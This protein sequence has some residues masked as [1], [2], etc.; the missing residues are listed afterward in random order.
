[1]PDVSISW[2][3]IPSEIIKRCHHPIITMSS[4]SST[5]D[6]ETVPLDTIRILNVIQTSRESQWDT[7]KQ[8]RMKD[9][10]P[11][12]SKLVVTVRGLQTKCI[13]RKKQLEER[14]NKSTDIINHGL[15]AIKNP[16]NK[17]R[18]G[19]N[20]WFVE[21][22]RSEVI[23]LIDN[24]EAK[25]SNGFKDSRKREF[26]SYDVNNETM[27]E[28]KMALKPYY[29]S[30]KSEM[31]MSTLISCFWS[32]LEALIIIETLS[33]RK[34]PEPEASGPSSGT[35]SAI[36]ASAS[37]SG[38]NND[39]PLTDRILME[40]LDVLVA[41]RVEAALKAALPPKSS[42]SSS[43]SS[44]NPRHDVHRPKSRTPRSQ[45]LKRVRPDNSGSNK[46]LRSE[47]GARSVRLEATSPAGPESEDEILLGSSNA[48]GN[49]TQ[50]PRRNQSRNRNDH[51][52]GRGSNNGHSVSQD[53]RNPRR[54]P[55]SSKG[56][57]NRRP[58]GSE[59]REA[60]TGSAK[61][62]V[63]KRVAPPA[64]SRGP[65]KSAGKDGHNNS[66]SH[67][68]QPFLSQRPPDNKKKRRNYHHS[69]RT[70]PESSNQQS[71][72]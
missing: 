32:H 67:Q 27:K 10:G 23:T 14:S 53:H 63:S 9:L 38:T 60:S 39:Q 62:P 11:E 24:I 6:K 35:P 57:A 31:N 26:D 4:L 22:D 48:G 43:S 34:D 52:H 37:A 28:F 5:I 33:K 1:M 64:K 13:K 15:N 45:N 30:V 65:A 59:K 54:Q 19:V 71:L 70:H 20:T 40:Q 72:N 55:E 41:T 25:L 36:T 66:S 44:H 2:T 42:S 21:S 7:L 46:K 47:S 56:L 18:E 12:V 49:G 50:R 69:S 3:K 17:L 68:Q 8:L 29:E 16:I 51:S 61:Q 58:Q